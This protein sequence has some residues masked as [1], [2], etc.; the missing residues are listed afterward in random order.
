MSKT[1]KRLLVILLILVI[2]IV[3]VFITYKISFEPKVQVKSINSEVES[4]PKTIIKKLIPN[5]IDLNLSGIEFKSSSSFTD[6]ELTDLIIYSI[7]N[8]N[9][10]TENLNGIRTIINDNQLLLYI[11]FDYKGIPLQA[12]SN[13]TVKAANNSAILHYNY[14]KV[15]FITVPKSYIFNYIPNNSI[16]SKDE[17]NDDIIISLNKDYGILI[18]KASLTNGKLNIQFESKL[19]F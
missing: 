3:S 12:I 19:N 2:A 8:S 18:K 14:T 6:N 5:N 10:N 1:S 15:G 7:N 17:A 11:N 9:I 4:T 13:F 16:L